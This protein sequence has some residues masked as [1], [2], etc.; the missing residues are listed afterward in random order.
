MVQLHPTRTAERVPATLMHDGEGKSHSTAGSDME[1]DTEDNSVHSQQTTI[2]PTSYPRGDDEQPMRQVPVTE[3][4]LLWASNT[5]LGNPV[6][7][8]TTEGE[9]QHH[10]CPTGRQLLVQ[11]ISSQW[12]GHQGKFFIPR[13]HWNGDT[14]GTADHK[15]MEPNH[16]AL[17]HP[18]GTLLK[19]WATY[20]CPTKNG[21]NCTVREMQ[22]TINRGPHKSAMVPPEAIAH[23]AIEIKEK[24]EQGQASGEPGLLGS[25]PGTFF[26][27][28]TF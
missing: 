22:A 14:V 10:K 4:P 23:F 25:N 5:I 11:P 13:E 8:A 6:I 17:Q 21:K 9:R 3:F 27:S 7:G 16:L 1:I 19:E 15:G 20:G 2:T 28:H 26:T 12:T 18:T 24:V